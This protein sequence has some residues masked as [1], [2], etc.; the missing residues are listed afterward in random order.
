MRNLYALSL[1]FLAFSSAK[2]SDDYSNM[3][4]TTAAFNY[5]CKY[6]KVPHNVNDFAKVTDVN[7][8]NLNITMTPDDWFNTVQFQKDGGNL[9]ILRKSKHDGVIPPKNKRS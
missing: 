7:D 1:T 9:H 3:V 2:A 5:W 6:S 8:P 4:Y